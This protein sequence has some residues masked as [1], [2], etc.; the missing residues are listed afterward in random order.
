MLTSVYGRNSLL[1]TDETFFMT[2]IHFCDVGHPQNVGKFYWNNKT[3]RREPNPILIIVTTLVIPG[4]RPYQSWHSQAA[5][6]SAIRG[7]WKKYIGPCPSL[8]I[9]LS[10]NSILFLNDNVNI[11]NALGHLTTQVNDI[12]KLKIKTFLKWV[13]FCLDKRTE[14]YR[15]REGF[16]RIQIVL[17]NIK[18]HQVSDK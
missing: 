6:S 12:W 13:G 9:P 2:L 18:V 15:R 3:L 14:R 17:V 4:V 16:H 8:C 5:D 11:T 7:V 10:P 1:L